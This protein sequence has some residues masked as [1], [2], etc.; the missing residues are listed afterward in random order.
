MIAHWLE[1][2]PYLAFV[3]LIAVGTYI[4]IAHRNLV[5]AVVGLYVLQTGIILF[6]ILLGARADGTVPIL[7][8]YEESEFPATMN[9]LPHALMLTAIV[10]GVAITGLALAIL[11]QEH[12]ERGTVEEEDEQSAEEARW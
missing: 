12:R 5:K 10:V 8:H 2:L 9:P 6:F 4:L 7:E 3:L 1:R 11:R